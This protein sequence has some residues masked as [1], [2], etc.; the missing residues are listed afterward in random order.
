M[1]AHACNPNTALK[2]PKEEDCCTFEGI[3][4]YIESYRTAWATLQN[5]VLK[6]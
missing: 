3:L 2:R 1:V 4:G 5:P 6:H